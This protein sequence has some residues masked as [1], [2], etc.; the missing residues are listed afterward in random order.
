VQFYDHDSI[1]G[2]PDSTNPKR[3]QGRVIDFDEDAK[4]L[5]NVERNAITTTD[6]INP[7]ARSCV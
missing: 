3:L 7:A 5:K 1:R 4:I 2:V 6:M